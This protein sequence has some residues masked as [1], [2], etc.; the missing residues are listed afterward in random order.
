[1]KV[2]IILV[3][4]I[5][6]IVLLVKTISKPA[7]QPST[8]RI[9]K[10][11]GF[12]VFSPQDMVPFAV[13]HFEK[14]T[15][16][17]IGVFEFE[18]T[19]EAYQAEKALLYALRVSKIVPE[20]KTMKTL[21]SRWGTAYAGAGG[22]GLLAGSSS[23]NYSRALRL[24]REIYCQRFAELSHE[25]VLKASES[26]EQ[27]K[28]A[29]AKQ[30]DILRAV[31]RIEKAKVEFLHGDSLGLERQVI[32]TKDL[33]NQYANSFIDSSVPTKPIDLLHSLATLKS[34]QV[35]SD[36]FVFLDTETTGLDEFA[37]VVEVAVIDSEGNTLVDTL[38]KPTGPIPEAATEIHGISDQDVVN[39][40]TFAEVWQEQLQPVFVDKSVCI[41]NAV[42]DLRIIHQTLFEYDLPPHD[43]QKVSCIMKLYA[44]F[45]GVWNPARKQKTW[46]K[47]SVAAEQCGIPLPS[48]LHRAGADAELTRGVFNYIANH[49]E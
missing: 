32:F 30:N 29:K 2:L 41:W 14:I 37:E 11:D 15:E 6:I 18:L 1:M 26:A 24:L 43:I 34:Q 5:G 7:K 22:Q 49:P 9:E 33:L 36:S 42:F 10:G 38:V 45:N 8:Q 20:V 40:P 25:I 13:D 28:T 12:S 44:D 19:K 46:Q 4:V 23:P 47:L 16:D 27:R 3:V 31:N 35:V 17:M 21:A 39:S 48:N